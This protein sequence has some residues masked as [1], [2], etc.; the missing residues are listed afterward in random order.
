[1]RN[2]YFKSGGIYED[3]IE[4]YDFSAREEMDTMMSNNGLTKEV[5]KKW[6][7]ECWC[8]LLGCIMMGPSFWFSQNS[9]FLFGRS[10]IEKKEGYPTPYFRLRLMNVILRHRF[11]EMIS[12][13]VVK[14]MN[15]SMSLSKA[16]ELELQENL[17]NNSAYRNLFVFFRI[18][19]LKHFF[20]VDGESGG[21][22]DRRM[23]E[24][25]AS[26]VRYKN[27]ADGDAMNIARKKLAKGYPIPS[28]RVDGDVFKERP[29]QIQE[30]LHIANIYR[31]TGMQ[32]EVFNI[33]RE[34]ISDVKTKLMAIFKRFDMSVLRSIQVSEWFDLYDSESKIGDM[35]YDESQQPE[36][37][38]GLL[39]DNYIYQ[40][41]K[42]DELV[43]IP[44]MNISD[45]LGSTSFDIRLGTSLQVYMHT[46]YGVVD[47]VSGDVL[48]NSRTLDLDYL[49]SFTISP[50]QFV[51]GHSMEYIKLPVDMA[52]QVEGRS[53]FARLGL[54]VHMTAGFVD[55]GFEG[56]LTFEIYNAGHNPIKLYPGLRIGQLRFIQIS[57]PM[58]PYNRNIDAKYGGLLV[59]HESKQ[60]KDS[61][62]GKIKEKI[63][64]YHFKCR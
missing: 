12:D 60:F 23:N 45:Q 49:E 16:F 11:G 42:S 55:P 7:I 57:E 36:K 54:Q 48:G 43:I 40:K 2:E 14:V 19:F 10:T 20:S 59:Q 3:F 46:K 1:M 37:G 41:I 13:D 9:A 28:I 64:E 21:F 25:I 35:I 5:V 34:E 31:N 53:S 44:I 51:L 39:N 18:F 26:I 50:S 4:L 24:S 17:F 63:N 22:L 29:A 32:E 61:E 56:V 6:L 47:F 30:I 33:L 58:R 52:A 27:L 8:D 62:V 15:L 38:Y